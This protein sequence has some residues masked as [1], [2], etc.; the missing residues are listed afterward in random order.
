MGV[1]TGILVLRTEATSAITP[2]FALAHEGI[3]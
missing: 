3:E 1:L 2:L